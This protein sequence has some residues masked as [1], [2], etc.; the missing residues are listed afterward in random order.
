VLSWSGLHT[1]EPDKGNRKSPAML[2]KR[3]SVTGIT[4]TEG[5]LFRMI[6]NVLKY[7]NARGVAE[8]PEKKKSCTFAC[9]LRYNKG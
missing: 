5:L 7:S 9:I 8:L 6:F 3:N 2:L 1:N 4:M